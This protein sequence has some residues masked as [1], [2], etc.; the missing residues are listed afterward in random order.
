MP[1]PQLLGIHGQTAARHAFWV[2]CFEIQKKGNNNLKNK[3][4]CCLANLPPSLKKRT[5]TSTRISATWISAKRWSRCAPAP[6]LLP[7]RGGGEQCAMLSQCCDPNGA[8]TWNITSTAEFSSR[9]SHQLTAFFVEIGT[10]NY[11]QKVMH[12]NPP[13]CPW[14]HGPTQ[15]LPSASVSRSQV[16]WV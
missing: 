2:L 16:S 12:K 10:P 13:A 11:A 3:K 1:R 6:R 4:I 15:L 9:S 5:K 7:C 8:P 14:H